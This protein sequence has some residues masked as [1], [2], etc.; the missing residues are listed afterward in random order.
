MIWDIKKKWKTILRKNWFEYDN[1][2]QWRL[3]DDWTLVTTQGITYWDWK[4]IEMNWIYQTIWFLA[5]H[6]DIIVYC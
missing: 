5:I 4:H 1:E 3:R 6:W 2:A